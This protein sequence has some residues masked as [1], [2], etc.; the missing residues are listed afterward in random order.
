MARSAQH[1]VN[2]ELNRSGADFPMH[3]TP[4]ISVLFRGE[5]R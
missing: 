1:E 3:F 2:V 4:Q 5:G